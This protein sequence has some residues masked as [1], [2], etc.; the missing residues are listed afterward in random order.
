V[1]R[2]AAA[3]SHRAAADRTV[4]GSVSLN[5]L[6]FDRL[7]NWLNAQSGLTLSADKQ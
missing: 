3:R 1:R 4:S 2:R 7:R 5:P 6:E